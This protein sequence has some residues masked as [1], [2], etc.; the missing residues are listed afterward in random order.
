[1]CGIAGIIG[2][3]P[4][5]VADA[6][7]VHRM[8]QT[9]TDRGPDDEGIYVNGCAGVGTWRLSIIDLC[10]GRQPIHNEDR[11]VW[12]VFNGEIY[13]FPQLYTELENRGHHFYTKADTEVIVHLYEEFGPDCVQKLRGMFA[14]AIWDERRQKL[15][16]DRDRFGKKP[17]HY[18]LSGGRLLFGSEIKELLA[19][20][21][22][23]TDIAPQGLLSSF[24]FGYLPDPLTAFA[25]IRKLPPGHLL[26]FTAGQVRVT[27]YWYLPPY[28]VHEPASEEECLEELEHRLAEAVR[29]RL[30]SDVP[31]GALLSGGVGSS[32]V[33]AL[34]GSAS[35]RLKTF[36]IGFSNKHFNET[37]NARTVLRQFG[38]DHPQLIITPNIQVTLQ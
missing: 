27:K 26:E 20:D 34:M 13:N 7:D 21:P 9:I 25:R 30:I 14:F 38:T 17:L 35:R 36:S 33:V 29:I 16:L 31:L 28:G 12:V 11:T 22:R 5:Y 18:A 8:C 24:Y 1:M 23:L 10:S 2:T 32:I 4:G 19:A 37:E 3:E 15:L 6:A